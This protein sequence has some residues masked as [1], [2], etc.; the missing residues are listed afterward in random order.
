MLTSSKE[1]SDHLQ[2]VAFRA[3]AQPAS[4]IFIIKDLVVICSMDSLW[5][6]LAASTKAVAISNNEMFYFME[7]RSLWHM[8]L[9]MSVFKCCIFLM[10]NP[11]LIFPEDWLR[12]VWYHNL[13]YVS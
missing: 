12:V 7:N 10:F 8:I 5:D 11:S 6:V 9:N 3:R 4:Y 2:H 13:L 1:G